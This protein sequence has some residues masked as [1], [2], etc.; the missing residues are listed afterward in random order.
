VERAAWPVRAVA[1]RRVPWRSA[2]GAACPA[3][4]WTLVRSVDERSRAVS[5]DDRFVRVRA[6]VRWAG[7]RRAAAGGLCAVASHV[8]DRSE[9]TLV[10]SLPWRVALVSRVSFRPLHRS[11]TIFVYTKLRFA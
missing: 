1:V 5:R 2:G 11:V 9:S 7:R 8:T 10:C 6:V 4:V 3:H